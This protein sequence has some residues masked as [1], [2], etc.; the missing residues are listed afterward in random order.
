MTWPAAYLPGYVSTAAAAAEPRDDSA[1]APRSPVARLAHQAYQ[2]LTDVITTCVDSLHQAYSLVS[3][4]YP[5]EEPTISQHTVGVTNP[6]NAVA[7]AQQC[8]PIAAAG[9]FVQDP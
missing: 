9:P 7:T 5:K 8:A 4:K 2:S 3:W 6:G 1:N